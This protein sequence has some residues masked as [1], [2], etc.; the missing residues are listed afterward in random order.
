[1]GVVPPP[2]RFGKGAGG[3]GRQHFRAGSQPILRE[4]H[5]VNLYLKTVA[6]LVLLLAKPL[7]CEAQPSTWGHIAN[8]PYR[9]QLC[10][11]ALLFAGPPNPLSVPMYTRHPLDADSYDWHKDDTIDRTLDSMRSVGLN[12]I[13]LSYW[14]HEGETDAWCPSLLFSKKRWA[15]DSGVGDYSEAE[16]ISRADHFFDRA[17][18][19]QML[20]SPMLE[21]SPRFRF[22]SEF[23]DNL[24]NMVERCVWLVSHFGSQANWLRLYDASGRPR[25]AIWL[26]ETIHAGPVPAD[27]FAAAFDE[28]ARRVAARCGGVQ[29]GFVLAPTP[30]PANGSEFGPDPAQLKQIASILAI[31]PMSATAGAPR[32]KP[33]SALTDADRL[34]NQE[35]FL[36]RWAPTG[37]PLLASAIPGY[38]SHI[39]FPDNSSYGFTP[40]WREAQVNMVKRFG[41][42]GMCIDC[43]NGWTE[44]YGIPPTKEAED[45][46]IKW[47]KKLTAVIRERTR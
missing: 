18:A 12:T 10:T 40:S 33:Q 19:K 39:V 27:R 28:V 15:G 20:F 5:F 44:G 38:D 26:I 31:C 35:R 37:F 16:Q 14:G 7:V 4:N 13:K 45:A 22:Y 11:A 21:V 42:D 1:M 32:P 41:R 30:L 8:E 36:A 9:G 47:A 3:L 25:L 34:A 23:P 29:I 46:D 2:S 24:D 17:A 43:W 6:A